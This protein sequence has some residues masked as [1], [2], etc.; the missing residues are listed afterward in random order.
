VGAGQ[1]LGPGRQIVS[2]DNSRRRQPNRRSDRDPGPQ[3]YALAV[4][5]AGKVR[6]TTYI[7]PAESLFISKKTA[8]VPVSNLLRKLDLS[9]RVEAGKVGQAHGLS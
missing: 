9:N 3:P 8:S 1:I 5:A 6:S 7:L 4:S 2:Q